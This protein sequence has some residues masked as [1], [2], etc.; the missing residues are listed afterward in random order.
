MM[1]D[2]IFDEMTERCQE[3]R[4][5]TRLVEDRDDAQAALG[6]IIRLSGDGFMTVE[7]GQQADDV[8]F[9]AIRR[10]DRFGE[11]KSLEVLD[12]DGSLLISG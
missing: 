4:V 9:V 11:Q 6:A 7:L 2:E 10:F 12:V 8:G 3:V 1:P 5:F